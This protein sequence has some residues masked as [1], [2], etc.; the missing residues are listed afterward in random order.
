MKAKCFARV[1]CALSLFLC[2]CLSFSL[3]S[4][5]SEP[6]TEFARFKTE[7]GFY[8][9]PDLPWGSTVDE[10]EAVTGWNVRDDFSSHQRYYNQEAGTL[11]TIYT[12]QDIPFDGQQCIAELQFDPN[13]GLWCIGFYMPVKLRDLPKRFKALEKELTKAFGKPDETKYN[14]VSEK[15]Y[16]RSSAIWFCWD[17]EGKLVNTCGL[18]FDDNLDSGK[19]EGYL[20]FGAKWK[21]S[22]FIVV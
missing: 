2:F 16:T 12:G 1:R 6:K 8:Q 11:Q 9:H 18:V 22:G 17:E 4:C 15:N 5:N 13:G 7:E 14:S 21:D 20:M 3:A 10:V 19:E